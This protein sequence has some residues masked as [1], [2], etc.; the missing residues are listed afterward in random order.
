MTLA[1]I[2]F[3]CPTD[4]CD[5]R[6]WTAHGMTSVGHTAE[7][8][9]LRCAECGAEVEAGMVVTVD[10]EIPAEDEQPVAADGGGE[11]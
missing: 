10:G 4:D 6:T 11:S 5:S 1:P 9:E 2:R 3:G 7:V 8:R